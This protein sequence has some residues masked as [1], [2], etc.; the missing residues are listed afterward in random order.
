MRRFLGIA[1]GLLTHAFFFAT[2]PPLYRF[3]RNDFAAAP[4]GPLWIDAVAAVQFAI[5]HSILL[6]PATRKWITRRVPS[7]FY[8]LL[9]CCATCAS[10]WVL[11]AV[12]RGSPVIVW[13]WPESCRP[14]VEVGFFLS[15]VTLF[16]SMSLTGL[17]YQTGLTPWWHWVRRRPVPPRQFQPVGTYR[18][19]RHPVYLSF[20]GLVWLTPVVTLDRAVLIG[21]WTVYVGIGSYLKDERLSRLIGEPYRRYRNEVPAY[22]LLNRFASLVG[23]HRNSLPS[24][25]PARS[26]DEAV[27]L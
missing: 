27:R 21:L 23:S 13:A 19:V 9:F 24:L 20:L 10:L 18:Y 11:F 15:W 3:L 12:W 17:G 22:P 26:A 1:C 25:A 7:P 6:H 16:Y 5:P 8:G 2:L 14:A 4:A